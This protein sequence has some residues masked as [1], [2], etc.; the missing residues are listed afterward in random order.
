MLPTFGEPPSDVDIIYNNDTLDYSLAQILEDDPTKAVSWNS[1]NHTE[2]NTRWRHIISQG[3]SKFLKG[4][5]LF[6]TGLAQQR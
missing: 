6:G 5:F 1:N 2:V 3:L 4:N